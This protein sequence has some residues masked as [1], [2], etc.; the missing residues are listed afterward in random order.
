[1]PDQFVPSCEQ[2]NSFIHDQL[3]KY[4]RQF[5]H[6]FKDYNFHIRRDGKIIA[7]IVAASTMDTLEVEFLFVDEGYRRE[8]LGSKLLDHAEM[9]ARQNGLKRILLNTYSFQAPEFYKK[10]GYTVQT[11]IKPC[12]GNYDQYY[13]IKAL[14]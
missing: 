14:Q 6:T 1:M 3:R 12:F 7:G 5:M 2:D 13:F 11:V 4:N 9:L 10:H 8:G